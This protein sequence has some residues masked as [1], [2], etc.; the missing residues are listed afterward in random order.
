M[1]TRKNKF[2]YWAIGLAALTLFLGCSLTMMVVYQTF[3]KL[4]GALEERVNIDSLT[5]VVVPVSADITFAK[6][7]AYAVY[8]EY[9]SHVNGMKFKTGKQPP[10]LECALTSQ[11]TGTKDT[12]VP[13]FVESNTY[14]TKD[15]ERVGVLMMS[16]TIDD[17]GIYTFACQYRDGSLRPE[18]A[19]SVGP[20][21]MWEFFNIF[22]KVGG[23]ILS[24]MAVFVLALIVCFII[25]LIALI[26]RARAKKKDDAQRTA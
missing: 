12:A 2:N 3:P 18:I 14:R 20:N 21:L 6:P 4:P 1:N 8:Y 9:R 19:V 15:L 11:E 13:D 7:G 23:S 22:A 10:S 25:L 26:K 17:P 5:Q 16:F 24:G